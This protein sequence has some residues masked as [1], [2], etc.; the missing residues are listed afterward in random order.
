MGLN[1]GKKVTLHAGDT[2]HEGPEDVHMVGRNA[3]GTKPAR[4]VVV[5]IKNEGAPVLA[6]VK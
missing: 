5:L 1:G 3:S 2:F 6:P 4:F